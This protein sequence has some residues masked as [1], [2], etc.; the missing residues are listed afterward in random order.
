MVKPPRCYHVNPIIRNTDNGLTL[1]WCV[2][3][4]AIR[5]F[6]NLSGTKHRWKLPLL[7]T[8]SP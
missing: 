8:H 4:G 6:N 2:R 7:I 5:E 1:E 3:C